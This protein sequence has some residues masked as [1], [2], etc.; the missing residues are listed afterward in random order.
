MVIFLPIFEIK[1]PINPVADFHGFETSPTKKEKKSCIRFQFN[2]LLLAI[3]IGIFSIPFALQAES[4]SSHRLDDGLYSQGGGRNNISAPR[5]QE[6]LNEKKSST[7]NWKLDLYSQSRFRSQKGGRTQDQ[8]S[9]YEAYGALE[10]ELQWVK[11]SYLQPFLVLAPKIGAAQSQIV[12]NEKFTIYDFEGIAGLKLPLLP[13]NSFLQAGRGFQRLDRYGF[14]F[15]DR[16]NFIELGLSQEWM[17]MSLGF[18]L[19]S[20]NYSSDN[21]SLTPRD[22]KEDRRNLWGGHMFIQKNNGSLAYGNLYF[23]RSLTNKHIST[24]QDSFVPSESL[25]YLGADLGSNIFDTKYFLELGGNSL[26]S[27]QNL[28]LPDSYQ[29]STELSNTL[30]TTYAKLGWKDENWR[31]EATGLLQSKQGYFAMS[32]PL[33]IM[34]GETSILLGWNTY[35]ERWNELKRGFQMGGIFIDRRYEILGYS[36]WHTSLFI[37]S[38]NLELG[39]GYEGI[40]HLGK[41]S[42]FKQEQHRNFFL[43]SIA[44]AKVLPR[45]KESFIIDEIQVQQKPREFL[46]FYFSLGLNF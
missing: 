9:R 27:Y 43:A 2:L 11:A 28:Y 21:L 34:G 30:F 18:S 35:A 8:Q 16:M 32:G 22:W 5:I 24:Y 7:N 33:R 42:L 40:L 20:G 13:G 14:V 44:Y 39:R 10:P 25:S 45:E 26:K 1:N 37:N 23:Y 31:L 3:S 36:D 17:D 38:A 4:Y 19:V 6:F 41:K 12:Q 46:K 29:S 15:N